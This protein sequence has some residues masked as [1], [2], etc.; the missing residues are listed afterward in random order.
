LNL[1]RTLPGGGQRLLSFL[2][3][4]I[5]VLATAVV[6]AV[7]SLAGFTILERLWY[8]GRVLPGVAV[9]GRSLA[10][11]N[12]AQVELALGDSHTYP[13]TGHIVLFDG[14]QTWELTPGELGVVMDVPTM[15]RQ[16]LN[17]GRQGSLGE[18]IVQQY[19]AWFAGYEIAPIV[20]FDQRA[21][22]ARLSQI[23]SAI[24]RPTVEASLKIDGLT[25]VAEPGQ[26]GRHLN[27]QATLDQLQPAVAQM[28]DAV[29]ALAIAEESPRILDASQDAA[30][31][32]EALNQPL[33]LTAEG[34]DPLELPPQSLASMMRF[35]PTGSGNQ[36]HYQIELDAA[37]LTA[38]LE[39]LAPDLARR[40][41]NARFIFNDDT[42]QLDLLKPAVIGRQLDVAA[43]IQSTNAALS[44]GQ[45]EAPLAFVTT[46]PAVGDR[47][48]GAE[49]GI[50]EAVSV[51]STYFNGSSPERIQNI[52]TASG[53]FHGLL[54]A[55]GETLSMAD[56]LGDISLDTGY[57]EALII[58]GDR[59]ING[60]GGGVCQVS[61]T[62]FRAV[63]FG[64]Y[65]IV[66]RN[67]HAYRVGYYEQGPNS[68]GPGLDA[69]VFVPLV[70]FKFT[71]DRPYWLLMETYVYGN[72]LLWKFYSTSDGRTVKWDSNTSNKVDA[73]KPLYKENSD[74]PKG[75]IKQVD[76]QADGLD[77][78]VHRTVS[79][80]GETLYK[81]TI[82]THYLPWRAIFEYGPGTKLPKG[83]QTK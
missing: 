35:V 6:A 21:G 65:P 66:E 47:A 28:H 61:T 46:D 60:V 58:Y 74:L 14:I 44:A 75:E 3:R 41:E 24:D 64:G 80:D 82:K 31:A 40:P 7:A 13:A 53:A 62:L 4:G 1:S 25:V 71:N 34:A 29:A 23:A 52:T 36:A 39:L 15:A 17:V 59:T 8:A 18:R 33:R 43:S 32:Q 10:G 56:I 77:V 68:P 83:A 26:I 42:R 76:Y 78:V 11:M 79:R 9:D 2:E 20:I 12:Q 5:V 45:H 27:I 50:S 55:P 19:N 48:T 30:V 51:V 54:I 49:L 22:A 67:P 69:T 63:F 72:Q 38:Q 70:D 16:T 57:A 37:S 81:D 73:P